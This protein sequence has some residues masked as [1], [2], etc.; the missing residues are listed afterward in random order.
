[1]LYKIN[2]R[3][4]IYEG[5]KPAL[6]FFNILRLYAWEVFCTSNEKGVWN[7]DMQKTLHELISFYRVRKINTFSI[8]RR[9]II[10]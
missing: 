4:V 10:N 3:K 9:I 2:F 6:L 8:R 5:M 1:M 7:K